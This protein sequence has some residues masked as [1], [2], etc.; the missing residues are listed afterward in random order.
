VPPRKRDSPFS[1][2]NTEKR[3][4]YGLELYIEPKTPD[5][6]SPYQNARTLPKQKKEGDCPATY[7][8]CLLV[9]SK[10]WDVELKRGHTQL[11]DQKA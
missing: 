7:L 6:R 10:S 1:T 4:A 8:N 5:A 9:F 2:K 11:E 3:K